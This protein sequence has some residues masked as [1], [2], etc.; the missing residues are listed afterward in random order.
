MSNPFQ[1]HDP[2]RTHP[3][4]YGAPPPV[5]GTMP[6]PVYHQ[7]MRNGLGVA[8][9][10]IG[11]VG[12]LFGLIPLLF[13]ISGT[14]GLLAAIFG[15][16]G[17]ARA[18]RGIASNGGMALSGAILGLISMG[19]ASWGLVVTV[20]AFGDAATQLNQ[21]IA[22][23]AAPSGTATPAPT[24]SQARRPIA[25]GAVAKEPPFALK[26][27]SV[28]REQTV[29]SS[30]DNHK[31]QGAY[32][33]VR[34]LVKNT[35]NS[36]ATFAGTN[37]GILDSD[38]KQYNV[39]SDATISQNLETGQGLYDEINPGQRVTRVLVF[40]LPKKAAPVVIAMF[41]SEGS[42]GAFMYLVKNSD[43]AHPA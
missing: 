17:R 34:I 26:I 10:I 19:L 11:I 1:Q 14:L 29:S 22:S 37:S 23:D 30:I 28:S 3:Q 12:V 21:E 6:P 7:R 18:G 33:V 24:K 8:A 31:A 38:A 43:L 25:L 15:F 42:D 2:N 39:D 27:I 13:F 9:L 40:D 20:S 32:A 36:P 35:G 16:I 41:G 5:Y 4:A